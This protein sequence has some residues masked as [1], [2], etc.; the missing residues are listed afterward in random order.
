MTVAAL[1]VLS[2]S[3]NPL[4]SITPTAAAAATGSAGL[5]GAS[6]PVAGT[7]PADGGRPGGTL[8]QPPTSAPGTPG[9]TQ[10]PGTQPTVDVGGAVL[11]ATVY[12][13][14][15]KAEQTLSQTEPGCHL[16]WAMLAG[17]GQVESD[18]ADGG[19]VDQNGT[20]FTPILGPL[21]NGTDGTAAIP[22]SNNGIF[23]GGAAWDRA[24]GPM[25]FIPSTWAVWGTD[26]NGDGK[27]DPNNI[28]DAALT[29]GRYLCA[30]GRDLSQKSQLDR[31][32]LSYNDSTDYMNTVESWIRYF[33]TGVL[34]TPDLP[35][36]P[37]PGGPY[38]TGT[39]GGGPAVP[40][41]VASS[42]SP[43]PTPSGT[44]APTG[45]P[46]PQPTV[47]ATGTVT[48]PTPTASAPASP[49]PSPSPSASGKPSPSPSPT[50][51]PTSCPSP[52]A[53][54]T[55]GPSPSGSPSPSPSPSASASASPS[56][57]ASASASPSPSESGKP[58]ASPSPSGDPSAK[59]SPTACS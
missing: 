55:A 50:T 28:F 22:A 49:S 52:S 25:Q 15:Y 47:S 36:L 10:L 56:P 30:D 54:A 8:P 43:A 37:N 58:S 32:I 51:G 29:A 4:L 31:A 27:A 42:T 41:P 57:S 39:P 13:A 2:A 44:P 5:P 11:P 46:T 21:L 19:R 45:S 26:G 18:Q 17:I 24:V 48:V 6:A 12:A 1:A 7:F 23:D 59:P 33:S 40:G 16:Q 35:A 53:S 9:G 3:G 14:Y 34:T 38:A 20:T